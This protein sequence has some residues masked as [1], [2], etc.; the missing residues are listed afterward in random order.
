M[1]RKT[2]DQTQLKLKLDRET[3]RA[4][5]SS[6][7]AEVVAAATSKCHSGVTCCISPCSG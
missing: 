7:L 6:D 3:L 4:L 1:K 2:K 5:Q